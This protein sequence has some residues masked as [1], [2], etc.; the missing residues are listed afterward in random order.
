[1]S[2]ILQLIGTWESDYERTVWELQRNFGS[3]HPKTIDYES[4]EFRL[5]EHYAADKLT[6]CYDEFCEVTPYRVVAEDADSVVI[7]VEPS[8]L[9]KQRLFHVHF[10]NPNLYWLAVHHD[11]GCVYREFFRRLE[12]PLSDSELRDYA[13]R[14]IVKSSA[15]L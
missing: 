15:E 13:L 1:M 5:V 6:I 14:K 7:D 10:L 2:A 12:N 11:W 3:K 8:T 4:H 9:N